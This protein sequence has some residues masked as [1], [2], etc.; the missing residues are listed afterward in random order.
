MAN[1]PS[2]EEDPTRLPS[3][4]SAGTRLIVEASF[5]LDQ[6]KSTSTRLWTVVYS[7]LT[8]C[9]LTILVGATIAYSSPAL[10]ELKE[11]EDPKFRFNI[12]LSDIFGVRTALHAHTLIVL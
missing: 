10:L 1:A 7:V 3:V 4:G 11:L 2:R 5:R 9:L 8:T 12:Q 6:V